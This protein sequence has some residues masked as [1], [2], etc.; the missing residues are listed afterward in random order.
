MRIA[1][2]L[3]STIACSPPPVV[4]TDAYV[5]PTD[6]GPAEWSPRT[7]VVLPLDPALHWPTSFAEHLVGR[8]PCLSPRLQAAFDA[9]RADDA[10]GRMDESTTQALLACPESV[11]EPPADA[12]DSLL[13][14][15]VARRRQRPSDPP[16]RAGG[17]SETDVWL[18]LY[19]LDAA[20]PPDRP[21]RWAALVDDP[22]T[23]AWARETATGLLGIAALGTPL[24]ALEDER[25]TRLFD[26]GV[27]HR[28]QL[29]QVAL[30]RAHLADAPALVRAWAERLRDAAAGELVGAG[31]SRLIEARLALLSASALDGLGTAEERLGADLWACAAGADD[32]VVTGVRGGAGWIVRSSPPA[33]PA[34]VRCVERV[35]AHGLEEF[36]ASFRTSTRR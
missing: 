13:A 4:T 27:T 16:H 12:W 17:N 23:P 32:T 20:E 31:G 26:Q 8:Y 14:A 34:L 24:T 22:A 6:G 2:L 10:V 9:E 19:A 30:A 21:A 3:V 18:A 28:T 35:P 36:T 15:E 1:L 11:A 29:A 33:E 25:L 5:L 7:W